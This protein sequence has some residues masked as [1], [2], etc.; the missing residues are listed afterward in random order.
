MGGFE[1]ERPSFTPDG[2]LVYSVNERY[3]PAYVVVA[4]V[5]NDARIGDFQLKL[6]EPEPND[7]E[8]SIVFVGKGSPYQYWDLFW[9]H[10]GE[11][12]G[13]IDQAIANKPPGW[14]NIPLTL[15]VSSPGGTEPL[16]VK[17]V[18][19]PYQIR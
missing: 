15:S 18:T 8:V 7:T 11:A 5:L 6:I 19:Y 16:A 17:Q 14:Y 1:T 10:I 9:K 4:E 13:K 2:L 3:A 12:K